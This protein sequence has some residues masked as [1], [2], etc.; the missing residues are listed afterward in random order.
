MTQE[1]RGEEEEEADE[2]GRML[3]GHSSRWCLKCFGGVF[4]FIV[5]PNEL[6]YVIVYFTHHVMAAERLRPPDGSV[7]FL[8]GY[9]PLHVNLIIGIWLVNGTN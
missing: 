4:P 2:G 1:G 9:S 6:F 5:S 3:P 7:L 8:S